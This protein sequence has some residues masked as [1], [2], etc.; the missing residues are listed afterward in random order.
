MN[1]YAFHKF[2]V[3]G[4]LLASTAAC[5]GQGETGTTPAPNN[6]SPPSPVSGGVQLQSVLSGLNF[7]VSLVQASDGRIFYNELLTGS[8]RVINSNWQLD[9]TVFCSVSVQTAGEQGLLGLAL[10]PDFT[11]N[12]TLYVYYTAQGGTNGVSKLVK[13]SNGSCAETS[14]L[15]NLPTSGSHN[16][17]IIKF[18]PDGKLYVIIGD[19][20]NPSNAPNVD[21]L[22]GKV[23][24][25]N[26]DGSAPTDNPFYV[27]DP[28]PDPNSPRKKVY[29]YG[30]RNSFGFTFHPS[31]GDLWESENGPSS[32]QSDEV[33]RVIAG[34]NYG[35]DANGQ[36][37]CRNSPPLVDPIVAFPIFAP[38]GIVGI[39][40]SSSVYPF[41]YQGNLLV[42]GFN[43]G[44]IRLVIANPSVP[45][46]SGN[47]SVAFSGGLGGLI[48]MVLGS[49]GY[50]YVSS[51][52]G[53]I[54]RVVPH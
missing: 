42:A 46:G 5:S 20:E 35:W 11:T 47:T 34:G 19:A 1:Q 22:A 38:T 45:C 24:R 53:V 30:H 10:D 32:P 6:P 27:N 16:G 13:Q 9:P 36:S 18:G 52:N 17:G 33:N 29:S 51:M 4:F 40:A 3:M 7:P 28:N 37:G 54:Y 41:A 2:I 26:A 15:S 21:S 43:D 39:P 23:L 25:V 50:V 44:T 49:D 48:S 31:T 8:V 12:Q 14:I